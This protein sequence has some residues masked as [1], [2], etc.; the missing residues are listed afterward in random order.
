MVRELE[1]ACA[2]TTHV[3]VIEGDDL[4]VVWIVPTSKTDTMGLGIKLQWGCL[5]N[6]GVECVPCP[7]HLMKDHLAYLR[8]R[9]GDTAQDMPL[10]PD[11]LGR[12]CSKQSIVDS[13]C[14]LAV[15]AGLPV[16]DAL[17]RPLFGGHSMRIS[18]ARWLASFGVEIRKIQVLARWD[19]DVVLHYIKTAP[20]A[21]ITGDCRYLLQRGGPATAVAAACAGAFAS[22]PVLGASSEH[23]AQ[24]VSA[25][26]RKEIDELVARVRA[27]EEACAAEGSA[28]ALLQK[29][30]K[31]LQHVVLDPVV[32][33]ER[34][35]VAHAALA[36]FGCAARRS[37]CGWNFSDT[38]HTRLPRIP[39]DQPVSLICERCFPGLRA[40]VD[41]A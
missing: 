5:C 27:V 22:P 28:V 41:P 3:T 13:I 38:A 21:S 24:A 40:G 12:V 1:R 15:D 29:D 33:N 36:S 17:G 8:G 31:D 23:S 10:F 20:M 37:K 18:G 7:V 16:S 26:V 34:S 2:R 35:G 32:I 9:F 25:K 4:L 11:A 14:Q 30:F 19:S 39:A 6:T